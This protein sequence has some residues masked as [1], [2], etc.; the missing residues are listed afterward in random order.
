MK[1]HMA[2]ARVLLQAAITNDHIEQLQ[3]AIR[4]GEAAKLSSSQLD[5][6]RQALCDKLRERQAQSD[7]KAAA[8][9]TLEAAVATC[10]VE[11]LHSALKQVG[12]C[13]GNHAIF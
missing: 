5:A 4:E 13:V 12:L 2:E 3:E 10:E 8:M 7:R 6:A 9:A 1:S 11:A